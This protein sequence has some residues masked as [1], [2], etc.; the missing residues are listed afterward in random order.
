MARVDIR[1]A[2][3]AAQSLG[4][5]TRFDLARELELRPLEVGAVIERLMGE[6][7]LLVQDGRTYTYCPPDQREA[8]VEAE[9]R[10]DEPRVAA[11]KLGSFTAA[12]LAEGLGRPVESVRKDI[13][14][15]LD[16]GVIEET[17]RQKWVQRRGVSG[18]RLAK[19]Y[20]YRKV[21]E[22]VTSRPKQ[23]ALDLGG[24]APAPRRNGIGPSGRKMKITDPEVRKL[25]R[26]VEAAGGIVEPQAKHYVAILPNGERVAIPT[27]PSD[28]RSL[29]NTRAT[30]RRKGLAI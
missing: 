23:P 20:A 5:F 16:N 28:H 17:K 19:I 21:N 6:R 14:K 7:D 15:M 11:R 1:R 9:A 8:E 26:E 13:Q 22:I 29:P 12:E 25:V 3:A 2:T 4:T 27:T 24:V 30:L 10:Y 18:G